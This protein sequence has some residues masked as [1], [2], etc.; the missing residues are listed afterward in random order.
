MRILHL[1]SIIACGTTIFFTVLFCVYLSTYV[2]IQRSIFSSIRN[3]SFCEIQQGK[4]LLQNDDNL[5]YPSIESITKNDYNSDV[6]RYCADLIGRLE[7]LFYDCKETKQLRLP[8]CMILEHTLKFNSKLIGY[9]ATKKSENR[10]EIWIVFRGT[11]N[12]KEWL[13]DF[14]YSQVDFKSKNYANQDDYILNTGVLLK[15]HKGF[16]SIFTSFKNT[17]IG[18]VDNLRNLNSNTN[19]FIT[20]H[21]LGAA[22]ATLTTL[23]LYFKKIDNVRTYV[24]GSPRVCYFENPHILHINNFYRVSNTCDLVSS[25][26]L[27]VMPNLK[28]PKVPFLYTHVGKPIYFTENRKS[29]EHNHLLHVYKDNL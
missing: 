27:S 13:Y 4:C 21:S 8:E 19:I 24:F 6:A 18:K 17:L 29:L 12:E 7:L 20:G 5:V 26:P 25:L 28:Q 3:N 9:I 11:A 15:C 14:T 2:K 23:E 22:L 16:S 10:Q 1:V